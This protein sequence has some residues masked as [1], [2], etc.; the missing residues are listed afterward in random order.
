MTEWVA[1]CHSPIPNQ[2]KIYDC[3]EKVQAYLN[4][5]AIHISEFGLEE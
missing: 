1:K 2:P 3:L 5:L 4:T